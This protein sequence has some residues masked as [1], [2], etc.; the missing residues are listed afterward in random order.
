MSPGE[1][2]VV[3]IT[4]RNNGNTTWSQAGGYYLNVAFDPCGMFPSSQIQLGPTDS[5]PPSTNY[6]FLVQITAPLPEG[7]CS[8]NLRMSQSGTDF[9]APLNL[10][11]QIQTPANIIRDWIQYE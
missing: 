2:L 9:G 8:L 11:V 3:E 6:G 4:V 10:N 7:F 5:V 1:S